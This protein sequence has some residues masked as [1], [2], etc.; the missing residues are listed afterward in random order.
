MD[1]FSETGRAIVPNFLENHISFLRR[2]G[3]LR[4]AYAVSRYPLV[5]EQY[6]VMQA[7]FQAK[8]NVLRY[9]Y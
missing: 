7:Q 4:R 8:Q 9:F 3:R 6:R 1:I 2:F 5:G